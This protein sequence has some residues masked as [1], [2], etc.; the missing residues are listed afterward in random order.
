[1]V[2]IEEVHEI[3]QGLKEEQEDCERMTIQINKR[4]M[5]L[6]IERTEFREMRNLQEE[7]KPVCEL[8]VVASKFNQAFPVW[9]EGKFEN[10]DS[11]AIDCNVNEWSN[12]L[13]RLSKSSIIMTSP[14][15]LELL[16][17]IQ[18]AITQFKF[19]I[20]MLKSLR[21]K[22]LSLRHWR[23]LGQKMGLSFDPATMTLWKLINMKLHEDAK[24][25]IIKG[26]S[27]IATKEHA[28]F[29]GLDS[30]DKELKSVTF[31]F[32]ESKSHPLSSIPVISKL[33]EVIQAF[34][35]FST[36]MQ[37]LRSNPYIKNFFEKVTEI[38]RII[39]LVTEVMRDWQVFQRHWLYLKEVF[40]LSEIQRQLESQCRRF[41]RVD[42]Y[43]R[44]VVKGF[45]LSQ[46]VYL[47]L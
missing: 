26:V 34:D 36:R 17:F 27:E 4:E 19:Y 28:V 11:D 40:S 1:V 2:V 3:T 44:N 18:K 21:T 10:L 8:W 25:A 30:L 33:N 13:K 24:L 35:D 39:K 15:Q 42:E 31:T 22:G 6:G 23:L 12:E 9:F 47:A 16:H 45:E 5:M 38:E 41:E 29:T 43:Y 37:I 20:P 14:K 32:Q 46:K 7:L